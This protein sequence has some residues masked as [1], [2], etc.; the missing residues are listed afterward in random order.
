M[1][2]LENPLSY[3]YDFNWKSKVHEVQDIIQLFY[4]A[5]ASYELKIEIN[6]EEFHFTMLFQPSWNPLSNPL[7]WSVSGIFISFDG[8]KDYFIKGHLS[9]QSEEE[10]NHQLYV[11]FFVLESKVVECE[12]RNTP[13]RSPKTYLQ[14]MKTIVEN[15]ELISFSF[16]DLC[17]SGKRELKLLH[18]LFDRLQIL[19]CSQEWFKNYEDAFGALSKLN[20]RHFD[21]LHYDVGDFFLFPRVRKAW[22]MYRLCI[23]PDEMKS[24]DEWVHHFKETY[25][26]FMQQSKKVYTILHPSRPFDD[27][28]IF[29]LRGEDFCDLRDYYSRTAMGK[30]MHV[31]YTML[32]FHQHM[33][34][35]K[36]FCDSSL[37]KLLAFEDRN[38][39]DRFYCG[40]SRFKCSSSNNVPL[41]KIKKVVFNVLIGKN[42][43]FNRQGDVRI[44]KEFRFLAILFR[45]LLLDIAPP[46]IKL[47]LTTGKTKV[48]RKRSRVFCKEDWF[49][50]RFCLLRSTTRILEE[51]SEELK[52]Q[53]KNLKDFQLGPKGKLPIGVDLLNKFI[54]SK[55]LFLHTINE[56]TLESRDFFP[57]VADWMKFRKIVRDSI[58][59]LD[60][61]VDIFYRSPEPYAYENL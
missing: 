41:L 13:S 35:I 14:L 10:F 59:D 45:H 7:P 3:S 54:V 48:V 34:L 28:T 24:H 33:E 39:L 1:E 29:D 30:L 52:L 25:K 57:S 58:L 46:S 5:L 51:V 21:N 60:Y 40:Q 55:T 12:K 49:L 56:S 42:F 19:L 18:N 37:L 16:L 23:P 15:P 4:L 47:S 2:L 31:I 61:Q 53:F 32:E 11:L 44:V 17:N 36:S 20:S 6:P 22:L 27:S 9:I 50:R 26:W 8:W 38:P 43:E